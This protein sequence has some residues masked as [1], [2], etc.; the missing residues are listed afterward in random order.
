MAI[1]LTRAPLLKTVTDAG[2]FH[3][4]VGWSINLGLTVSLKIASDRPLL[5]R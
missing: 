3:G 4:I 5:P 1:G 2:C